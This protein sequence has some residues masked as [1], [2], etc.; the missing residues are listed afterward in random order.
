MFKKK[1]RSIIPNETDSLKNKEKTTYSESYDI[2]GFDDKVKFEIKLLHTERADYDVSGNYSYL[3]KNNS[4]YDIEAELDFCNSLHYR[5]MERR[6]KD[7][8]KSV[9]KVHIEPY[10]EII[11]KKKKEKKNNKSNICKVQYNRGYYINTR[12]KFAF[13]FPS[14]KKQKS[15]VYED[16]KEI[17]ENLEIWKKYKSYLIEQLLL[18]YNDKIKIKNIF[19]KKLFNVKDNNNNSN[20]INNNSLNNNI[21]KDKKYTYNEILNFFSIKNGLLENP[22]SQRASSRSSTDRDKD[23]LK[24]TSSKA[25]LVSILNNEESIENKNKFFFVDETFPPCQIDYKIMDLNKETLIN[26]KNMDN[27]GYKERY[28][29]YHYRPI[30]SLNPG[31]KIIFNKEYINPYDIK[32]GLVKNVN[33]ISIF[34]HIVEYPK[35]LEKIF[36]DNE[37]NEIGIYKVKL[38]FQGSWTNICLDKFIPCFPLDFPIYTYS[39][40]SLW[41]CLL[42]KALAKIFRGYDNLYK[43]NYFELYQILTG[44]PIYHFK[45]IFREKEN[46]SKLNLY[47]RFQL[48][49]LNNISN[50]YRYMVNSNLAY[51]K[52]SEVISKEDLINY[53]IKYNINNNLDF[54]N[55]INLN[56]SEKNEQD[57]I[58]DK[59]KY[60][61]N[62]NNDFE[63][64]N[65]YLLSFYASENYLLSLVENH[66]FPIS[67]ERIKSLEKK[68]F[69]VKEAN[70]KY[71]N[72]KSIYNFQLK[73]FLNE[74]FNNTEENS[75][76][77][78]K[79]KNPKEIDTLFIEWDIML[80]LFD[81]IIIVKANKYD[82]LHFRNAFIRCQ[83]IDRPDQERILAHTYY[84]LNIKKSQKNVIKIKSNEGSLK[85][86]SESLLKDIK[87]RESKESISPM[88]SL[89]KTEKKKKLKDFRRKKSQIKIKSMNAGLEKAKN[90]SDLIPITIT[91]NLSNEHFLDSSFYSKEL[92]MK[93]GVIKLSKN[94]NNN[95]NNNNSEDNKEKDL[96]DNNPL[97][98]SEINN[99]NQIIIDMFDEKNPSLFVNS[100]FQIGY[101]LVYDLF[102]E[103]GT[104]IIVPMT[105]GYCMQAN[106]KI[107]YKKYLLNDNKNNKLPLSKTAISKFLDDLFY[108][109]DPF[110][111]N[112]LT[113]NIIKE[114]TKSLLDSKGNQI[115]NLDELSFINEYSK[116]G[117]IELDTNENF[118][119]SRL[120]FKNMIYNLL[121]PLNDEYKKK[122]M[123]NLG[124]EENTYPYLNKLINV[125]FYFEKKN[126]KSYI[127]SITPKNNLIESNIDS[128]INI[129][130]LENYKDNRKAYG[131]ARIYYR[132]ESDS[133]YTIEGAYAKKIQNEK[134]NLET[135]KY[136]YNF[137]GEMYEKKKVYYST[138]KNELKVQ[139]SPG[140]LIFVLYVVEDLLFDKSTH[141]YNEIGEDGIEDNK[142]K[143]S[144]DSDNYLSNSSF[145][146]K[147]DI[148]IEDNDS[149]N[150]ES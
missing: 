1:Y 111:K 53:Y 68:L 86:E 103:E 76:N 121:N 63:E 128:I 89:I 5:A 135:K 133:W 64:N 146:K 147:S 71:I 93:L 21:Q 49:D 48:K 131:P 34:S 19:K 20:E 23:I 26:P 37:I 100:D 137:N 101:S 102:L 139:I 28:I 115:H 8:N 99:L 70:S 10:Q 81:N 39:S 72:V 30:E 33:I 123:S 35:I 38:F 148:K 136:Y 129:K 85:D 124:Y 29:V 92:D 52:A 66:N 56:I 117:N 106:P 97:Q 75:I 51:S 15:F 119:L 143:N 125:S 94:N 7:I 77:S 24:R 73:N 138:F 17:Q 105:M 43:V 98:F 6:N 2:G 58:K 22:I 95:N 96:G 74:L 13:T 14:L 87:K 109:N 142:D 46:S 120:S 122:S 112:Y 47:E 3:I 90:I 114:I 140:N 134:K 4:H 42:E 44:F 145:S 27:N 149:N 91:I 31:N 150:S 141:E 40:L 65:P 32:S 88:N 36:E 9:F 82:E 126:N 107:Y 12:I 60:I 108:I 59:E 104:Y 41:P 67:K 130:I 55:Y 50:N 118:G 144:Q 116:L 113:K 84:E 54:D 18:F 132:N 83:D 110:C 25:K 62:N 69:A 57:K 11:Q 80:T 127:I 45:K 16:H 79:E 78:E 61:F